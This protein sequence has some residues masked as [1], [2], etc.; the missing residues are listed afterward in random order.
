MSESYIKP[1]PFCGGD[2]Y[3]YANYNNR[4]RMYFVFVKCSICGASGKTYTDR[5]DPIDNNWDDIS[6]SSA[7]VAWNMRTDDKFILKG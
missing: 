5:E 4:Y 7:V 2:G 1:C 6:C 3:L